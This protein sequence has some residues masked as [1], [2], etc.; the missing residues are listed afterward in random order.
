MRSIARTATTTTARA[1][2]WLRSRNDVVTLVFLTALVVGSVLRLVGITWALTTRL[3]PDE[4]VIVQGA[5]DLANRHSFEPSTFM[6]PDHVEIQLSFIAY[7][8]YSH[9]VVNTGVEA[10]YADSPGTFLLISRCIAAA[11]GMAMI[12]LAYFIGR[13]FDRRIGAMAAVLVALMPIFVRDSHYAAPDIP[14]TCMLMAVILA[15]MHYLTGP[16]L[17]PLFVACAATAVGIAIKYPAAIATLMIA[18]VV[19]V[20]AVRD[21]RPTRI[22]LHGVFAVAAVI[23]SLF[24]ISPVLFTNFPAVLDQL[25]EQAQPIHPGADGLGWAGN[26]LF[27]VH[28]FFT[29]VGLLL[30][31]AALSGMVV[32]V[33]QRMLQAIPLALGAVYWVVLSGV[34]IHWDRWGMPM[35]VTPLM[36]AAIGL[37]HAWRWA[38]ARRW[39]TPVAWVVGTV[40][41][42]NLL[43][44]SVAYDAVRLAPDNRLAARDYLENTGITIE[45]SA[46]EGYSPLSPGA[47]KAMFREFRTVDGRLEPVDPGVRWVIRSG[48]MSERYFEDP[49]YTDE[50]AFY[51][52]VPRSFS[53]VREYR[54]VPIPN[55]SGVELI[56]IARNLSQ[57][58][59]Y[60]GGGEAGCDMQIYAID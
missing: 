22:L 18:T 34:P 42:T 14:L 51:A 40:A 49:K 9:L 36:F 37:F 48:C 27:Y 43:V 50:R 56:D 53:L 52:E 60:I 45:N 6:R 35:Y 29:D 13:R 23:G 8:L 57:T 17:V 4:P 25:T 3:H 39:R 54:H 41:V 10:A 5:L 30:S 59:A 31:V 38:G 28:W 2:S 19:I 44:G 55:R 12:V 47:S 16:R 7:Q 20:S 46:Y 21:R 32:A 15:L 58:E 26:L 33:R 11:F 24:V 1:R